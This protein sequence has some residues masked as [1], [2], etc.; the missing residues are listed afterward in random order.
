MPCRRKKNKNKICAR[1]IDVRE[2]MRSAYVVCNGREPDF[3]NFAQVYRDVCVCVCVRAR[4]CVCVR[5]AWVWC[6]WV[7]VSACV[8]VCV[9]VCVCVCVCVCL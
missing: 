4:A 6:V 3:T 5:V 2:G 8:C 1:R 9:R 7:G